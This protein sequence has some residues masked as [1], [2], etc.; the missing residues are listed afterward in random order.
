[1]HVV[2]LMNMQ[3]A[4]ENDKIYVLDSDKAQIQVYKLT[5]RPICR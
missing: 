4:I 5:G 1:M 3:Y 2:G